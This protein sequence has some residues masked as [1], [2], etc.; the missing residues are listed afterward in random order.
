MSHL[1]SKPVRW[2]LSALIRLAGTPAPR[3]QA[4][5][6]SLPFLD[7]AGPGLQPAV[8]HPH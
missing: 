6:Q 7:D 3:E 8:A 2:W 4:F 1:V 5:R